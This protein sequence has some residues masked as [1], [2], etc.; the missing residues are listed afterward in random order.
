MNAAAERARAQSRA[1]TMRTSA[2]HRVARPSLLLALGMLALPVRAD[3][4]CV[5]TAGE[6]TAYLFAAGI[7][8]EDDEIRI[9][10]GTYA[11]AN[12]IY[13]DY[14]ANPSE[15]FDLEVSGGWYTRGTAPCGAQSDDPWETVLDGE[16]KETV[17]RLS[18]GP[19]D[20]QSSISVRLL[21]F[22][23]GFHEYV[24]GASTIS[25]LEVELWN[26]VGEEP[27]TG[28][29]TI[30]RNV[31]LL[32]Q[33][34]FMLG[35]DG[36]FQ[37]ITNNL[38][39]LNQGFPGRDAAVAY[40][41]PDSVFGSTFTNNTVI[42]NDDRGLLIYGRG[43][44]VNNNFRDNGGVDVEQGNAGYDLFLYNN[45]LQSLDVAGSAVLAGNIDVEPEYQGG[46]FNYTPVRGSPLVDAGREPQGIFWYLTDVDLNG[47]PRKVG[48]HVDIGA[49]ENEKIFADG[50]DPSGPFGLAGPRATQ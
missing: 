6:L 25:G 24:V 30:E 11:M 38:M 42:G 50:F 5:Q 13:Y 19:S 2:M 20:Q 1:E 9:R 12:G 39:L 18:V 43:E 16:G 32:N 10:K 29:L 23:N 28:T 46:L 34:Q 35:V 4:F 36:G 48:P 3:V 17:L 21:T 49:F 45:N 40:L 31:F 33:G 27:P 7:N 14:D 41:S 15:N 22:M 26:A 47:S 8:L 37:R 44:V